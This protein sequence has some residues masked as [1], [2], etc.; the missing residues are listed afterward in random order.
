MTLEADCLTKKFQNFTA[1]KDLSFVADSGEIFGLIGQNGAGKTTTFRMILNLLAPTS[2]KIKWNGEPVHALNRDMIGYL[3]EERGMY[4]KMPVE[5]QLIFFG[6]LRGKGKAELKKETEAW[7][8]RFGLADKRNVLTETLSKGNQQKVQ[9]IA[10]L[11]HKPSLLILDEPFSGLDPVNAGLLKEAIID[12]KERG[13]TIIFSSHRMDHVE[14]LCDHLCLL[15]R[16]E[17]L[18]TG[19]IRDLKAQFGKINLTLRGP[20]SEQLLSGMPGVV[21]VIREKD[22]FR[23]LLSDEEN[24]KEIFRLVTKNGF[25]ERF[26]LDYLSLEEIFKRKV[27]SVRV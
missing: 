15:K 27:G 12:L 2:G 7:L 21:S 1:V 19:A 8:E 5:E 10:S 3:P 25:I 17:S 20:F 6:R 16:G 14:E 26:S 13:A 23:L 4:P 9:L 24:A 11:I 22:C 18:F